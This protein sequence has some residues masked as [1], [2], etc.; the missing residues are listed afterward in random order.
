MDRR[1]PGVL[2]GLAMIAVGCSGGGEVSTSD[3]ASPS[4]PLEREMAQALQAGAVPWIDGVT[5]VPGYGLMAAPPAAL[6]RGR[7]EKSESIPQD[8]S[9]LLLDASSGKASRITLPESPL[10]NRIGAAATDGKIVVFTIDAGRAIEV[11]GHIEYTPADGDGQSLWKADVEGGAAELVLRPGRPGEAAP[12]SADLIA[13]AHGSI[14][15]TSSSSLPDGADPLDPQNGE[16]QAWRLDAKGN[17]WRAVGPPVAS[18]PG[19]ACVTGHGEVV[20]TSRADGDVISV[21]GLAAGADGFVAKDEPPITLS[22]TAG[23]TCGAARSFI[24]DIL[25]RAVVADDGG[26]QLLAVPAGSKPTPS[27][28]VVDIVDDG[29]TL[30]AVEDGGQ[31]IRWA[32]ASGWMP[33]VVPRSRDRGVPSLLARGKEYEAVLDGETSVGIREVGP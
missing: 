29:A 25:G 1:A 15:V 23:V 31:V 18:L 22:S 26:W 21:A 11:D 3:A 24:A 13:V 9:V 28:L 4:G 17:G 27:V 16:L 6:Q 30:A 2:F 32:E 7:S 33:E 12:P 19:R 5:P 14:T 20:V 10:F 8:D